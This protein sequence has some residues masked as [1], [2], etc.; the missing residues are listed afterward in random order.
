MFYRKHNIKSLALAFLFGAL[1]CV[2]AIAIVVGM[3]WASLDALDREADNR[4]AAQLANDKRL[5]LKVPALTKKLR[6]EDCVI[7]DDRIV[8]AH[9]RQGVINFTEAK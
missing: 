3:L 6:S 4:V 7:R 1:V 8:C 9:Y 2:A 5:M